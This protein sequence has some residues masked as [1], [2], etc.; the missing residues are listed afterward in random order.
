MDLMFVNR[1]DEYARRI[2]AAPGTEVFWYGLGKEAT[3][4]AGA[5]S[6]TI[7]GLRFEV[8]YGQTRFPIQSALMG[9]INVYNILAACSAGFSFGLSPETIAKGIAVAVKSA[10]RNEESAIRHALWFQL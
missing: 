2:T 9:H 3:V 4:R 10:I 1:D 6:S 5:V 8:E 7:E